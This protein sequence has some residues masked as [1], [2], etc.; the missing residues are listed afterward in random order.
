M[1]RAGRQCTQAPM[2]QQ[3][4]KAGT[5]GA[6]R[7]RQRTQAHVRQQRA[8]EETPGAPR[9]RQCTQA[10]SASSGPSSNARRPVP[11]GNAQKPRCR[12]AGQSRKGAKHGTLVLR[13]RWFAAVAFPCW[14]RACS[15]CASVPGVAVDAVQSRVHRVDTVRP[16][17]APATPY[18]SSEAMTAAQVAAAAETATCI[19]AVRQN[20]FLG[21]A[22]Q[23]LAEQ[24]PR[25][26]RATVR[27]GRS[28]VEQRAVRRQRRL[29]PC[30]H[31]GPRVRHRRRRQRRGRRGSVPRGLPVRPAD[32]GQQRGC[33]GPDRSHRSGPGGRAPGAQDQVAADTYACCG[34]SPGAGAADTVNPD[35]APTHCP[36]RF[37]RGQCC[38]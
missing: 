15:D 1:R 9:R 31:P 10:P 7:G 8:K 22:N 37:G 2:R 26:L 36:A 32:L 38:L 23:L 18:A 13:A 4:A 28:E 3:R 29:L 21:A 6:P 27:A 5:P 17:A 35:S 16:A 11:G 34:A 33:L 12:A 14:S 20:Q 30:V 19:D 24:G 25:R